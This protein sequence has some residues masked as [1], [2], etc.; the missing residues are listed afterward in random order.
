MIR[1]LSRDEWVPIPGFPKYSLNSLGQ[2]QHNR[3]GRLIRPQ[4][5]RTG[6]V[7]V[8]LMR[9]SFQHY[10]RSLPLLVAKAFIPQDLEHLEYFDTPIHLDGDKMNCAVD[11]LMWRPRWFSI[12]FHNQFRM[13]SEALINTPLRQLVDGKVFRDSRVLASLYGLLERDILESIYNSAPVWPTWQ[14]FE[15]AE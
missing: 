1:L 6:G 3:T 4:L 14:R 11:N 7:Y 13:Y 15:L 9:E 8:V 2:V 12:K 10:S 5:N